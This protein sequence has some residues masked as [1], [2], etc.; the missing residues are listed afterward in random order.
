MLKQA[1][2]REQ[3]EAFKEEYKRRA[4]VAGTI[5]QDVN[6]L[7]ARHNR[8]RGLARTHLQHIATAS[9][10]NLRR[11]AVWLMGDQPGATRV[12]PFAALVTPL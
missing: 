4:A 3:T 1:H 8:Y 11:I 10:I 6:A 9:A 5:A 12:S 2:E 7:G